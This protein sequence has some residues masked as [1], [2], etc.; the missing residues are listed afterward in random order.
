MK[1]PLCFKGYDFKTVKNCKSYEE[2]KLDCGIEPDCVIIDDPL[3]PTLNEKS[4]L[5]IIGTPHE[6]G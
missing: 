2:Y 6:Q 1:G 4:K 5:I 3:R